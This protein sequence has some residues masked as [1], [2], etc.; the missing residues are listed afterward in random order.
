M[1]PQAS[2]VS[3]RA[4]RL[5]VSVLFAD[6]VSP[7]AGTYTSAAG[8][9]A[10]T[11]CPAG[12]YPSAQ[13][14]AAEGRYRCFLSFRDTLFV[15]EGCV[16]RGQVFMLFALWFTF[17]MNSLLAVAACTACPASGWLSVV[18]TCG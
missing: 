13:R 11:S 14:V 4:L 12:M 2:R 6:I 18:A 15:R 5:Q 1:A 17:I 10:C 9:S 8:S 3:Y 16:G 7:T